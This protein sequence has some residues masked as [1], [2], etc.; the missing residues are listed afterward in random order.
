VLFCD[1]VGSTKI[2]GHLD[3]EEWRE[4]VAWYHHAAAGMSPSILATV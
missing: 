1:L 3:P 4:V 2:A